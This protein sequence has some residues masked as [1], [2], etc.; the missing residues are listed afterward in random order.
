M[1]YA[2]LRRSIF[3]VVL[4]LFTVILSPDVNSV[5]ANITK[6]ALQPACL[7]LSS[8]LSPA[9]AVPARAGKFT[10]YNIPGSNAN[11]GG[12]TTGPDGNIWF[13]TFDGNQIGRVT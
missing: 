1:K 11:G 9:H 12:I 4:S 3:V 6:K 8:P 5:Q 7:Q 13:T 2:L 10:L